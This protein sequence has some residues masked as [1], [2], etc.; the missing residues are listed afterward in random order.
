MILVPIKKNIWTFYAIGNEDGISSLLQ[1]LNNL[2]KKYLKSATKILAMID[3][4]SA[5]YQGPTQ[6]PDSISHEADKSNSIYEFI[7]G[8]VRLLWF[9]S[10]SERCVVICSHFFIKD[11]RKTPMNQKR[12]AIELKKQYE[13]SVREK[14]IIILE[15]NDE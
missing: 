1:F 3:K 8:D 13:K 10:P 5:H 11:S 14:G 12:K 2:E 9:Y 7:A 15:E 4:A 6:F